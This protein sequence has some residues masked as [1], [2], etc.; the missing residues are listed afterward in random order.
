MKAPLGGPQTGKSP[1]DRAKSGTKRHILT[2]QRGAPLALCVTGANRHG[3]RVA[4]QTVD[5]IAIARPEP[6]AEAQQNLC[7]DKGYDFDDVREGLRERGYLV[8][9]EARDYLVILKYGSG[10]Q[11]NNLSD[12]SRWTHYTFVGQSTAASRISAL[13]KSRA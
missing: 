13:A 6:T 1:T 5:A 9:E 7:G 3:K 2:D 4:L 11:M 12:L 8:Q 10:Q